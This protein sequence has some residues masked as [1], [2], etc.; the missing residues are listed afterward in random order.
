MWPLFD[1]ARWG[2]WRTRDLHLPIVP[3]MDRQ[4]A[5]VLPRAV[6]LLYLFSDA[7]VPRLGASLIVQVCECATAAACTRFRL[8]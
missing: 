3:Y 4:R 2:A 1:V 5:G 6:P 8:S 7:V